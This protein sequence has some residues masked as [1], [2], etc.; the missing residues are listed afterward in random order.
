MYRVVHR[1]ALCPVSHHLGLM[2]MST[3]GSDLHLIDEI[4]VLRDRKYYQ[5]FRNM[6]LNSNIFSTIYWHYNTSFALNQYNA[7]QRE[8]SSYIRMIKSE[9]A[10]LP[11]QRNIKSCDGV[12]RYAGLV[13]QVHFEKRNVGSSTRIELARR[14]R[15]PTHSPTEGSL[16]LDARLPEGFWDRTKQGLMLFNSSVF[17]GMGLETSRNIRRPSLS[18]RRF[19]KRDF[20]A[21][22]LQISDCS[23]FCG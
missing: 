10:P 16:R 23:Y 4:H 19:I 5:R 2:I 17:V 11:S 7:G 22:S 9:K 3:F 13:Q 1:D 18:P 6:I 12:Q 8:E 21:N 20:Y 15:V 14:S